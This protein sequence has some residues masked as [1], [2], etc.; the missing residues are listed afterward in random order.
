MAI[1]GGQLQRSKPMNVLLID[2]DADADQEFDEVSTTC[3][4]RHVKTRH[5]P[6]LEIAG[7][8]MHGI[9][10]YDITRNVRIVK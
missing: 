7:F 6:S 2:V 1:D 9:S 4:S 3:C 5:L 10:N 8:K